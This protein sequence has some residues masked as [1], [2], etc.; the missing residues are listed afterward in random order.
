MLF[1]SIA[2]LACNLIAPTRSEVLAVLDS[3]PEAEL[4]R[5]FTRAADVGVG[6]ELNSYDMGFEESEAATILRIFEIA[7]ACGCK[8][9]MGSDAHHPA[10]FGETKAVFERAI[11]YL[12]LKESDKFELVKVK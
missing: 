4:K 9:Y 11:D 10:R 1:R 12:E 6:I 2:H 7:K 8:F 5:C 3:L